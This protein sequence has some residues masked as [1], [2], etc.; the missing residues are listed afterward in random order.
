MGGT[1]NLHPKCWSFLVGVYRLGCWG[2]TH[3]FRSCPHIPN[4]RIKHRSFGRPRWIPLPPRKVTVDTNPGCTMRCHRVIWRRCNWDRVIMQLGQPRWVSL[5]RYVMTWL[6]FWR[7]FWKLVKI[8]EH[9][10]F[11]KY[12]LSRCVW[13]CFTVYD[14]YMYRVFWQSPSKQ[15]G[16]HEV[17][18]GKFW[19]KSFPKMTWWGRWRTNPPNEIDK[20]MSPHGG[21]SNAN[22]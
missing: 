18:H 2:F 16:K 12:I 21:G 13:Y 15:P 1:P 9:V 19:S 8:D 14:W 10:F 6:N 22:S 4:V 11:F 17:M 3:H 7:I 20:N 5:H